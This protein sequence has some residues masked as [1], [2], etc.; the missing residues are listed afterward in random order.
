[1]DPELDSPKRLDQNLDSVDMVPKGT[2]SKN[3][4]NPPAQCGGSGMFIPDP[5]FFHLG[6]RIRTV[7]IPK[8]SS[9]N[10]SILTPKKQKN[11][12]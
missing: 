12:F 4:H 1:M 2:G 9:K 7:S 5:T 11:G 3:C 8:S 10:F 6:S